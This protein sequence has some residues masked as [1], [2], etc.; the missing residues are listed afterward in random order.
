MT[1]SESALASVAGIGDDV[2]VESTP[3]RATLL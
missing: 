3:R 2:R 1:I